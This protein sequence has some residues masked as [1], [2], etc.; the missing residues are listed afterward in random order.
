MDDETFREILDRC[1]K[2]PGF[3]LS[4]PPASYNTFQLCVST[5]QHSTVCKS[6]VWWFVPERSLSTSHSTHLLAPS[7]ILRKDLEPGAAPRDAVRRWSSEK[8]S[9]ASGGTR[10]V[11]LQPIRP[12]QRKVETAFRATWHSSCPGKGSQA[13][14]PVGMRT[15]SAHDH[16]AVETE[17]ALGSPAPCTRHV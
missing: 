4:R 5:P 12:W 14:R 2:T 11:F 10:C 16:L 3:W 7:P 17:L 9:A 13:T 1:T 6:S 8:A 15:T